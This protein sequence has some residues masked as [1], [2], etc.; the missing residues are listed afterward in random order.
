MNAVLAACLVLP[1][2]TGTTPATARSCTGRPL[3]FNADGRPDLAV[4]APYDAARA[5]SVTV[6]YG[7]GRTAKLVQD[8]AEPGDAFGSALAAGDFNGDRCADLAVGVSEEFT[9]ERV[10]GGD[11]NG[12]VQIYD[13]SPGGLVAGRRLAPAEPSSDRFGASLAAGDLDGDGRDELA[14][15]SPGHRSGGAVTVYWMKGRK[16]Y[17]ITQKTRWVRQPARVT[18]QWAA[19]LTT[20]DFDGDGKDELVVGAPAD[21]ISHDGQG[22]ATVV[23]V[24]AKRARLL[25]QS[26]PGIKGAAEKWDGFGA[27][28]ATGDFNGDGKDDLAIGVPGEGLSAGQRAMDYGDGTVDVLYGSRG[29]LRTDRTEA[30]SQNTLDGRPRYY[31]RFGASLAA[32][33]FNGDGRDDL[34]IGVPGEKAV[35]V[36]AGRAAGGLTRKGNLLVKG[37]GR[38]FGAAVT[39]LPGWGDGH[40]P[41]ARRRPVYALVVAAPGQGLVAY[42]PGSRRPGLRLGKVR[43]LSEGTGLYGYA[44]G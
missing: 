31:D 28:L 40:R 5:G 14:V 21:S 39:A 15:G 2:L 37:R 9:G 22:S 12:V 8:D 3:D 18:D 17:R 13:G 23:D 38:D 42:A 41:L 29:G 27:S 11:G 44:F 10:P 16:P 7:S 25:H 26:T 30:W 24:R 20:G 35:Q 6:T 4:A 36:L 19:A 1:L 34:A 43:P 33:D 32:G